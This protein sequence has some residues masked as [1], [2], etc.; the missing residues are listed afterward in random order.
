MAQKMILVNPNTLVMKTSHVPDIAENNL[1]KVD[2][3]MKRIL[4]LKNISDHEK[5]LMYEQALRQYLQGIKHVSEKR[6]DQIRN[7]VI[8]HENDSFTEKENG[9]KIRNIEKRTIE[10]LP[11][12]M[13]DKGMML[14]NH[15]KDVSDIT[16]N[17]LGE[18]SIRG[19]KISGSNISDLLSDT[20]RSRKSGDVFTGWDRFAA[21]LKRVNT[22][23]ELIGNKE[24][25]RQSSHGHKLEGAE[26][27][28]TE[29][30]D[31]E[32]TPKR[33]KTKR[34]SQNTPDSVYKTPT[35]P[36]KNY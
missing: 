27:S 17:E 23:F 8:K 22:P 36:W 15:I 35:K 20:I 24:R 5:A 7:N 28:N 25:Y 11:K 14:L 33:R 12:T 18:I 32:A 10:Y 13:R 19:E 30:Y 21:E 2:Q 4:D 26:A 3:E 9:D 6:G 29:M 31:I 34:S 1:F 16:W